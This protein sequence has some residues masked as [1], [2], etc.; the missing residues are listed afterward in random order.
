MKKM[1]VKG[2][3]WLKGVHIFFACILFGTFFLGPW[4]N[5]MAPISAEL[6]LEALSDPAYVYNK[7]MNSWLGPIQVATLIFAAF[8][9]VLKP[10]KKNR[11]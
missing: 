4:L 7:A 9:S 5:S 1:K 11:G 8:I 10:W 2:Q 6:G 3:K